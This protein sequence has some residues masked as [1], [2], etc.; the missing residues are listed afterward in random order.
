MFMF[1][2]RKVLI[3]EDS[4]TVKYEVSLLLK[5]IGV[6][7]VEAGS[8]IGLMNAVAEFGRIVDLIIMDLSLKFENG[9]DLIEKLKSNSSYKDIPIIVLTEHAD[10]E[11]VL[12]AK[13]LGVKSYL[14]KP[15][16]KDEIVTR[17]SSLLKL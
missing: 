8:E 15:I 5:Q 6:D 1:A 16:Q 17:V 12:K 9:F 3:V 10:A 4:P 13:E 2:K 7:L 11:N 14:R